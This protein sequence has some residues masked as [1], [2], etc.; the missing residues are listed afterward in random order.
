MI[1]S[2]TRLVK[3]GGCIFTEKLAGDEKGNKIN[4]EIYGFVK[5]W[6]SEIKEWKERR[7]NKKRVK[8]KKVKQSS[9]DNR[10][11]YSTFITLWYN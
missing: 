7:E 2:N 8:K 6:I 1:T 11:G 4:I 5:E 10:N 9:K 3:F